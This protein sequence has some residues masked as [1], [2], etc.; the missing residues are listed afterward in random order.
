M[1]KF[2]AML[3]AMVMMLGCVAFAETVNPDE[4]VDTVKAE[5]GEYRVEA[6][7]RLAPYREELVTAKEGQVYLFAEQ[8]GGR[9][10]CDSLMQYEI[11]SEDGES[12]R[13]DLRAETLV[14]ARLYAH[15]FPLQN[16]A[17]AS[18]GDRQAKAL[19]LIAED[20]ADSELL[21]RLLAGFLASAS[22][23]WRDGDAFLGIK[24]F[25][26][27]GELA[28]LPSA[29]YDA[30]DGST[31]ETVR[32]DLLTLA[33]LVELLCEHGLLAVMDDGEALLERATASGALSEIVA[34]LQA[35]PR[36]ALVADELLAIAFRAFKDEFVQ[37]LPETDPSY[38][39]YRDMLDAVASA[40]NGL[41]PDASLVEQLDTLTPALESALTEYG[42][43]ASELSAPLLDT[44]ARSIL[45]GVDNRLGNVTA[46]DIAS[47]LSSQGSPSADE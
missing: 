21:S 3:L 20:L 6:V 38:G 31:P 22:T 27:Q 5:G 14:L 33:E 9:A 1:K 18:F 23:E 32:E 8:Y 26:M 11:K 44:A 17:P 47:L 24:P 4:I 25:T 40:V 13:V 7:E 42:I 41:S 15:S 10:I 43:S 12:T 34:C 29:L 16:T 2:L 36:T 35:N 46:D 28:S 39:A 45:D 19:R 30:L 37:N